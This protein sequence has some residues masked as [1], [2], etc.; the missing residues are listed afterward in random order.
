MRTKQA[1]L[2]EV[3]PDPKY[4]SKIVTQLI[5]RSMRD[6]KKTVAQ[7]HIYAALEQIAE[8]TKKQPLEVLEAALRNIIPQMEVRTRRVGGASYQVP[9]PV[10]NRRGDSLAGGWRLAE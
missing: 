8:Q 3:L 7:R 10:R 2:R 5:N 4:G 6:G 9:M 1:K